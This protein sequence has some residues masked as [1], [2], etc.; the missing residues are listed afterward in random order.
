VSYSSL[1]SCGGHAAIRGREPTQH[2]IAAAAVARVEDVVESRDGVAPGCLGGD[3]GGVGV[4]RV[5]DKRPIADLENQVMV[6]AC[7]QTQL[8]VQ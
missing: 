7:V 5:V 1:N 3:P 6:L 2:G 4:D 8:E